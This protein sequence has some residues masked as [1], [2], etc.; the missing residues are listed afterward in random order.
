[1]S[2]TNCTGECLSDQLT[3]KSTITVADVHASAPVHMT[4]VELST[5]AG[6]DTITPSSDVTFRTVSPNSLR[7]VTV[8]VAR[9]CRGRS[10]GTDKSL[11]VKYGLSQSQRKRPSKSVTMYKPRLAH[12]K[13]TTQSAYASTDDRCAECGLKEP[14]KKAKGVNMVNW[15]QCDK[16]QF[17]YH[18]CCIA[19]MPCNYDDEYVCARC[20]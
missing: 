5:A 18:E 13:T 10:K 11:N 16:C 8:P 9:W 7:N 12:T 3:R 14:R 17:W 2:V 6:H 20:E 19:A 15:I 4:T 1:M